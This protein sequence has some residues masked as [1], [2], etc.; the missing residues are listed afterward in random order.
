VS[1]NDAGGN[2]IELLQ[3][4]QGRANGGD[5]WLRLLRFNLKAKKMI[6]QTYSPVLKRYETDP[7]SFFSIPLAL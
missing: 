2:I 5:G 1:R 4:Y 7:D 6:V 3:D